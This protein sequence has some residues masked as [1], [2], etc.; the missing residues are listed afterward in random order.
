M[1]YII[2]LILSTSI[3]FSQDT[4]PEQDCE[5]A[6]R[7]CRGTLILMKHILA[8]AIKKISIKVFDGLIKEKKIQYGSHA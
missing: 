8:R 7:I 3:L 4:K 2:L 5:N 6:L 1:K